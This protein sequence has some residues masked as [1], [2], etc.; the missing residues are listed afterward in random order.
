MVE[1][2]PARDPVLVKATN[3]VKLFP[4]KRGVFFKRTIG[5]VSAVDGREL[6]GAEGRDAGA[7]R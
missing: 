4:I 5:N 1:V 3:L 2:V 7:C 6:R